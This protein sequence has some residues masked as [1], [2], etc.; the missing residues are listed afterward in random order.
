M[1]RNVIEYNE[2]TSDELLKMKKSEAI[3]GLNESQQRF[4]EAFVGSYNIKSALL[5]AGYDGNTSQGTSLLKKPRIKRYIQWL[6]VRILSNS[7]VAGADVIHQWIKIAF[8]DMT[9]FVDIK[10]HGIVLKPSSQVDGQLIKSIK[11]GPQGVSIELHDKLKALDSLAKYIQDMPKDYKQ[12]IEERKA[13]FMQNEFE[14]K[15]KMYDLDSKE[16]E[17]DGFLEALSKTAE[18]VWEDYEEGKNNS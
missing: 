8:A 18:S 16:N 4:C 13:D 12:I 9:D 2:Y 17:D 1:V 14:L 15:K 3:E 6:K 7:F 10:P 11:S 5:K